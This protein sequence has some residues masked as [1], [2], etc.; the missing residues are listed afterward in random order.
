MPNDSRDPMTG[1]PLVRPGLRHNHELAGE[2][3]DLPAAGFRASLHSI[4]KDERR[5]FAGA[6]AGDA[7]PSTSVV[8]MTRPCGES[9][10][11]ICARGSV[12]LRASG[13]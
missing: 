11:R 8:A 6:F 9:S 12:R 1:W 5:S 4:E 13:T 10:S 2:P 7:K 3:F